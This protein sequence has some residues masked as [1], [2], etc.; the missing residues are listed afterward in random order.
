MWL[1]LPPPRAVLSERFKGGSRETE[2][3]VMGRM[4][5][6]VFQNTLVRRQEVGVAN[7]ERG[8]A[9]SRIVA[10]E[11]AKVVSSLSSADQL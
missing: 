4:L 9:C 1:P 5:H 10:E 3:M 7:A 8:V 11:I 6:V 2:A